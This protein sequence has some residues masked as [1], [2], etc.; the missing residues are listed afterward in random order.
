[1]AELFFFLVT[2]S[3][4]AGA[5]RFVTPPPRVARAV[6]LS[7]ACK[8][9]AMTSSDSISGLTAAFFTFFGAGSSTAE[10]NPSSSASLDFRLWKPT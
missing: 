7:S 6:W 1:L 3:F 5:L 4:F 9:A 8:R 10:L 2:L